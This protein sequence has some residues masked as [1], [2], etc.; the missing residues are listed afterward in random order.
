MR[1]AVLSERDL[2]YVAAAAL[3]GEAT[4]ALE[5][6]LGDRTISMTAR[7]LAAA[8][9]RLGMTDEARATLSGFSAA[10][11]RMGAIGNARSP[12]ATFG[13]RIPIPWHRDGRRTTR[14]RGSA[15][16]G[17]DSAAGWRC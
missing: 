5:L 17:W 13:I 15:R 1:A 2:D 7:P 11:D 6:R 16:T 3:R 8:Q 4:E 10:P 9:A 14:A 12:T